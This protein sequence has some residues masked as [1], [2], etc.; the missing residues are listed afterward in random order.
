MTTAQSID[1]LML[2]ISLV[3]PAIV[4]WRFNLI[5]IP[6]AALAHWVILSVA[7]PLISH[8]DPAR[9]G[10]IPDTIW[11]F[12]G[13]IQAFALA[14]IM[15]GLKMFLIYLKKRY[16]QTTSRVESRPD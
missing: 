3:I 8:F 1:K 15:F 14:V 7:G 10:G 6:I 12:L 9:E 5:G 11:C 4:I 16:S 13:W 2:V